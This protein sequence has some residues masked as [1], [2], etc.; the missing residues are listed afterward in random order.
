MI[1][2]LRDK[3]LNKLCHSLRIGFTNSQKASYS[4][5]PTKRLDKCKSCPSNTS[6]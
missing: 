6:F 5:P 2:G 1:Y 4:K 3:I